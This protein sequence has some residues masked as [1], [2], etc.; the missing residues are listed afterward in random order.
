MFPIVESYYFGRL[1]RP[2][3]RKSLES[4]FSH[5]KQENIQGFWFYLSFFK[6]F[7]RLIFPTSNK[8]EYDKHLIGLFST[9][10]LKNMHDLAR[11]LSHKMSLARDVICL[12]GRA[13]TQ[14]PSDNCLYPYPL[15]LASCTCAEI[16]GK[17]DTIRPGN[18]RYHGNWEESGCKQPW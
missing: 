3:S 5:L 10:N 16:T 1:C 17:D 14:A 9:F 8:M 18:E 4:R 6:T 2:T 11:N 15:P 13:G 12:I 7:I